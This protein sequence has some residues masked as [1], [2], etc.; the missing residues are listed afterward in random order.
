VIYSQLSEASWCG[1][2]SPR[3]MD[4]WPPL[5]LEVLSWYAP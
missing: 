3:S 4:L 5:R 2:L 1:L